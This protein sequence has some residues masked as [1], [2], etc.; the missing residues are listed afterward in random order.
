MNRLCISV[1]TRV[2]QMEEKTAQML[3]DVENSYNLA[4]LKIPKAVRQ[5]NWLEVF[6]KSGRRA[7][8]HTVS[9]HSPAC[10]LPSGQGLK[11]ASHRW[12]TPPRYLW[13]LE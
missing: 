9:T 13:V 8:A 7:A 5:M 2:K 4:L 11:P 3:K 1:E 10:R 6:S 12:W